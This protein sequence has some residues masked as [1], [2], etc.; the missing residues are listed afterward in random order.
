[1]NRRKELL[2]RTLERVRSCEHCIEHLPHGARPIVQ[3]GESAKILI[4]GQA[5]GVKVHATGVAFDDQSGDRLRTWMGVDKTQ[6][7]DATKIA[8]LPMGFCYPGK[9][10][11]GDLPPRKECAGLWR[12]E[13]L[14]MMTEVELT[15]VI[16]QYAIAWHLPQARE[17]SLT[18]TV[19]A[20]ETHWPK[21]LPLP[22]PSPR[23]NIWFKKNDWFEGAIIPQL[24]E[25]VKSLLN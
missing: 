15:L 23:N 1:M 11:S 7:Y 21:K 17:K 19:K 9:G 24:Q 5:P 25:R 2:R 14:A 10:K 8:I 20:W 12:E 18:E 6:F 13:L 3:V 4:V 22:H 16:G